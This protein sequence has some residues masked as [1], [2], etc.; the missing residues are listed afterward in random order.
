MAS[1]YRR[2]YKDPKT[3]R[4]KRCRTYTIEWQDANGRW[5]REGTNYTD[6]ESARQYA[7]NLEKESA[8]NAQGLRDSYEKNKNRPIQEHI[9]EYLADLETIG[10]DEMYCYNIR[11]RL[12]K[13]LSACGWQRLAD[14][15]ANGFLA[16]RT[17]EKAAGLAPR[18]LNQYLETA[19]AWL[20]WLVRHNKI[21][22]NPLAVVGK[23]DTRGKAKRKRRALSLSDLHSLLNAAEE[24]RL[25]YWTAAQTGLRRAEMADL[26]WYDLHIEQGEPSPYVAL[27]ADSTKAHRADSIPLH[28]DLAEALL[29]ARP[30]DFQGQGRVFDSIPDMKTFKADLAAAGIPYKDDAGRQIDFH[31]LR[32]TFNNLLFKAGV[33][34]HQAMELM[35][36]TDLKL[37]M[38]AYTD[39]RLLDTASAVDSLPSLAPG[40]GPERQTVRK[41]GTDD[42]PLVEIL[43]GADRISSHNESSVDLNSASK[44][45]LKLS[46]QNVVTANGK[47]QLASTVTT[48]KTPVTAKVTGAGETGELGF[49]PR[50]SDPESLVLPLHYSPIN[51]TLHKV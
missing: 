22:D 27:R 18:T 15:E 34:P 37:T 49:E 44:N 9:D 40:Q 20:N 4:T 5:R 25:T 28:P 23:L 8:Q 10:R 2:K 50:L 30:A 41:T 31:A 7:C 26:R 43:V 14:I 13:L 24:R 48:K 12:A 46:S 42:I 3:G 6:R 47:H 21:A 39:P 35:R 45:E 1:I 33:M 17:A 32:F 29:E 51:W 16:W 11:K 38:T 19:R 36:H